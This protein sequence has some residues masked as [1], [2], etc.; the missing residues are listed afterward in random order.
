MWMKRITKRF[1]GLTLAV[2]IAVSSLCLNSSAA[3][4]ILE[5]GKWVTEKEVTWQKPTKVV[6]METQKK[7][8][9][10]STKTNKGKVNNLYFS[11][12][13]EGG[14][15]FHADDTGFWNAKEV[16][17]IKYTSEGAA[18]VMQAN[19]TKVKVYSTASPWRFEVYNADLSELNYETLFIGEVYKEF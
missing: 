7:Q 17:E 4:T 18:I 13:I 9:V 5:S 3:A 12:P 16:S 15:R 14:V 6:S 19:D 8:F 10:M 1:L 2:L 11:F